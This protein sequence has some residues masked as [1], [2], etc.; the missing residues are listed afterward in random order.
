MRS[1]PSSIGSPTSTRSNVKVNIDENQ[2][3]AMRYGIQSIPNMVLFESAAPKASAVGAMPKGMLEQRLGG[4]SQVAATARPL[5]RLAKAPI[6][7]RKPR[8]AST[9]VTRLRPSHGTLR[10]KCGCK[11][12]RLVGDLREPEVGLEPTTHALQGRCSTS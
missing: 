1:R 11:L 9:K 12:G 10:T 5:R 7:R 3:L 6:A 8:R 4:A 2:D